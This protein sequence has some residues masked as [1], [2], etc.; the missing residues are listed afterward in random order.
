MDSGG[1]R[2]DPWTGFALS[3]FRLNGSIMLAGEGISRS[4]GQSSA[5]W[6]VLGRVAEPRTVAAIAREVGYARQSVQRVADVLAAEGLVRYRDHPTDGRTQLLELTS[7][8][9]AVV[10]ALYERQLAWSRRVIAGVDPAQLAAVTAA[11]QDITRVIDSVIAQDTTTKA[12]PR[13]PVPVG[14]STDQR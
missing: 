7:Q 4:V 5:R 1:P 2:P 11:M 14:R 6:Q 10:S 13:R 8:G 9:R 3:V 12:G